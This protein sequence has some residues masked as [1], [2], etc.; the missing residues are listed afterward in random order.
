MS[1]NF[2]FS[3]SKRKQENFERMEYLLRVT[4]KSIIDLE[5]QRYLI[6]TMFP[7]FEY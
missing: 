2:Y 4:K 7:N 5:K 6:I 1:Y 3:S